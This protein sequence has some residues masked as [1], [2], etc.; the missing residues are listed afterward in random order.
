M[1]QKSKDWIGLIEA[2]YE[3]EKSDETWLTGILDRASPLL[4]RG[5]WPTIGIYNYTP[6]SINIESIETHGPALARN[7]LQSSLQVKTTVVDEFF[8]GGKPVSSLSE[9]IYTRE[10]RIQEVVEEITD[11]AVKDKFAVKAMSGRNSA[12]IMCWL[13]A[14]QITPTERE[15]SRWT[16]AAAHLG[17][18]L[19]LR[20]QLNSLTLDALPVEAIFDSSGKLLEARSEA[21]TH[22][23]RRILRSAVKRIDQLRTQAGRCNP[24]VSLKLWEGLV[25]GRWSIVDYFDTDQRR[26][27]VAIKNTPCYTNP[28]GLTARERQV[29]ELVGMGRSSKEI[30]YTLGVSQ[31]AIYNCTARIQTKLQLTSRAELVA[32]FS[33]GGLRARL[34]EIG[35]AGEKML[36]GKYPLINASILENLTA[37]EQDIVIHILAG[38]TNIDI[39]RRRHT[40]KTTVAKQVQTIFQKLGVR[41]RS[42]LAAR[43]QTQ[44]PSAYTRSS[45]KPRNHQTS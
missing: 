30:S 21:T 31:S 2:G 36:V 38:L 32:F 1:R 8:R 28:C 7:F 40:R 35:V 19:R 37:A 33:P 18:G 6:L 43:L 9:V 42:E 20:K 24:D 3:L 4:G 25:D 15:R 13:F 5:F 27:I 39:A 12:L 26:F 22:S 29:A 17:A 45:E 10:P 44:N 41:S 16:Q 34:A 14:K 11:G 23:A